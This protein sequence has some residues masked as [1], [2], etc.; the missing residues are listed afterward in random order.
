MTEQ[1]DRWETLEIRR[2]DDVPSATPLSWLAAKESDHAQ[3]LFRNLLPADFPHEVE[4]GTADDALAVLAL[5]ESIRRDVEHGTGNRVHEALTLGATWTQ[6]AAALDIDPGRARELLRAYADGQRRLW[7]GYEEE[8]IKPF[9][10]SADQHTAAL[11]LCELGD[12]ESAPAVA[13]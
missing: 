6:V 7:V 9:G 12:D 11:A 10:F 3:R 4:R 13:R 2:P 5:R 8:G 1:H